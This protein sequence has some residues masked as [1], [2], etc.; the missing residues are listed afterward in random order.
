MLDGNQNLPT[1][2]QASL[3]TDDWNTIC[4][5]NVGH[6]SCDAT[7]ESAVNITPFGLISVISILLGRILHAE[8]MYGLYLSPNTGKVK[9]KAVPMFKHHSMKTYKLVH[10]MLRKFLTSGLDRGILAPAVSPH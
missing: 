1:T 7:R 5:Q 4:V 3:A 6:P 8:D 9:D 2:F 10:V